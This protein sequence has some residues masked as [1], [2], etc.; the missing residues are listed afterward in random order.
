MLDLEAK[1]IHGCYGT[2]KTMDERRKQRLQFLTRQ[3]HTAF[4][5]ICIAGDR[6]GFYRNYQDSR[7]RF[8]IISK[9]AEE[10]F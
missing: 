5:K 3:G 4:S 6:M 2:H 10:Y 1:I 7:Q 8:A 9:T